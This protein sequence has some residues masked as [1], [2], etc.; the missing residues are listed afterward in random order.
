MVTLLTLPTIGEVR[1]LVQS[2]DYLLDSTLLIL[3]LK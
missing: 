1:P 3:G 2:I